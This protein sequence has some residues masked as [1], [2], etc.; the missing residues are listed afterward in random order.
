MSLQ[1]RITSQLTLN[2]TNI[3]SVTSANSLCTLFILHYKSIKVY[4]FETTKTL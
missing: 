1:R 3:I 4:S 2:I